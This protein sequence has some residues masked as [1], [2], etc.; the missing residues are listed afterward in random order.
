MENGTRGEGAAGVGR[1]LKE[2]KRVIFLSIL[3]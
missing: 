1:G 2:K 3:A